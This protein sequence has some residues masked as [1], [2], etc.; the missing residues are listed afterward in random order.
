MAIAEKLR[1]TLEKL[2][3]SL[4]AEVLDYAEYLVAKLQREAIHERQ[5]NE[6][7]LSLALA[8]RGMEGEEGPAYSLD[9]LKTVF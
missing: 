1:E 3:V 5:F 8:M 6:R 4:Q 7:N 2:P 9:D